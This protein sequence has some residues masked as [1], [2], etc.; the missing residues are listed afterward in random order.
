MPEG[1]NETLLQ[2]FPQMAF[3]WRDGLSVL[4]AGEGDEHGEEAESVE[5]EIA[6]FSA[7]FS[8]C[9][10]IANAASKTELIDAEPA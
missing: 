10:Q 7:G 9:R 5:K 4:D 2:L 8:F 3:P 6:G 1:V